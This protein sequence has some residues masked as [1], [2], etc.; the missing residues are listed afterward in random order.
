HTQHVVRLHL[1]PP[2]PES[3]IDFA[4]TEK[5]W[6]VRPVCPST[7]EKR[8]RELWYDRDGRKTRILRIYNRVIFDE[9]AAKGVRLPF[10]FREVLDV[11]WAGHPNWYFRWSKFS[12]PFL[13]HATKPE[14]HFLSDLP[15]PPSDLENWVLKPLFSFAGGGVKVDVTA[16]DLA[17]V[18]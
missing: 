6:D 10:D 5:L 16:A 1:A 12:L 2:A 15:S 17:A 11:S 8:G 3:Y 9:L 7:V 4:L 14:A 18:T 13:S